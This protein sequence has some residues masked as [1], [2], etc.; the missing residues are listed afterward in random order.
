MATFDAPVEQATAAASG[1]AA[2]DNFVLD[3]VKGGPRHA[4]PR[5]DER[6]HPP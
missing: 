5:A 4:L 1:A 3:P 2:T 6:P